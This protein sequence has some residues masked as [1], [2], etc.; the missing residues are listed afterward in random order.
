MARFLSS[1]IRKR[2]VDVRGY[3]EVMRAHELAYT[4]GQKVQGVNIQFDIIEDV[5]VADLV[6][7]PSES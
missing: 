1:Y 7:C 2:K 4:K 3:N 6:V 5:I